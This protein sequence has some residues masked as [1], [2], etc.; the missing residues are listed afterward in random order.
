MKLLSSFL[1]SCCI[2]IASA[3]QIPTYKM[4]DLV[5]RFSQKSDTIYVINFWAT[6]CKPCVGE[7][8]H[9]IKTVNN[10]HNP[11][12]KLLLVSLDLPS[13]Y[14]KK[15]A[16]FATKNHF[17]TNIAWLDETNADVFCPMIDKSWSGS[18]PATIFVNAKTGEKKFFEQELDEKSFTKELHLFIAP[19]KIKT[20]TDSLSFVSPMVEAE[21]RDYM[22]VNG[23]TICE[24]SLCVTFQ[25]FD[26]SVYAIDG[27]IVD[28]IANIEDFKALIIE[29]N[30]QYYTYS[31]LGN[32]IVK[33]GDRVSKNQLLGYAAFDLENKIPTVDL[34]YNVNNEMIR[35][36]T[37]NFTIRHRE[38]SP[39]IL[40]LR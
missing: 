5:E 38:C 3:Q 34:Y 8:P 24:P 31:N 27:G 18:I 2:A 39:E 13:F 21:V 32:S 6:F 26:S 19:K 10:L 28:T 33:K 29:N 35:L 22:T 1:L 20:K 15:I 25:S 40:S 11:K 37:E 12:I 30:N 9:F 4:A 14:P 36:Q 17:N 7:I 23:M 16:D